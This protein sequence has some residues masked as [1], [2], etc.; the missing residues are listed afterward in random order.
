MVGWHFKV[1]VV[2]EHYL[3]AMIE[4]FLLGIDL[5]YGYL[6]PRHLNISV[7]LAQSLKKVVFCR[8]LPFL[9]NLNSATPPCLS[10]FGNNSSSC[11]KTDLDLNK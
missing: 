9:P 10:S 2:E 1:P 6:Q 5:Y 8:G 4:T 11:Y 7:Y 3:G